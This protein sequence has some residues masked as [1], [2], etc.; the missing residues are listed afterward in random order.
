MWLMAKTL[1]PGGLDWLDVVMLL[2]FGLTLPWTVIG[3]WNATIGLLLMR[4]ADNSLARVFP[5][6]QGDGEG[7]VD[8]EGVATDQKVAI[9]SC[10]RNEDAA[11]V[12]RNLEQIVA[13]LSRR[14]VAQ[15]FA[16]HVLS[17][18]TWSECISAEERLMGAFQ[19]R[20]G[21]FLP[22]SYRRRQDNPG[23]KAG[24]IAEFM[25]RCAV[26]FDFALVLDADSVMDPDTVLRMLRIMQANPRLGILQSLVVG[27][28]SGSAFARI[29]QFGMRFGMRSFTLGSAWWQGDCGPY[30]GH[31]ALLRVRPFV[32]HCRLAP[33]SGRGPL[34]GWVLSHDQ[35]EAVLMRRAGYQVRVLPEESGSYEENP[36]SLLEYIRR[37][38]RWCQG[39]LQYF[40]LLGTGGLHVLGRVQLLLAILMFIGSP[41]WVLLMVMAASRAFFDTTAP[42]FDPG[43]G[44]ALLLI[45]LTM[46]FA[47]KL[48]S[49]IDL[50]ANSRRRNA[51]GGA[52]RV[53]AGALGEALFSTLLAPVLAIAHSVFIGGLLVG[54]KLVWEPQ[55]RLTHR[56]PVALAWWR[57]WPQTLIG[58]AATFALATHGSVTVALLSPFFIGALVAVPLAVWSASPQLGRWVT[59][60]RLWAIPEEFS[61]SPFLVSLDL[62]A[63]S[64]ANPPTDDAP[65]VDA[66]QDC[67][68]PVEQGTVATALP[69]DGPSG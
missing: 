28:P 67:D 53:L 49:L 56:V 54:R 25:D 21:Q 16:V 41:F 39:N 6:D 52:T 64:L 31:N 12:F 14:G 50:L 11:T 15:S 24:N 38:L 35:L 69:A 40:R 42:L 44:V 9:L 8:G 66:K 61:P 47:P 7:E 29:F 34:S 5:L 37:D 17:D 55:R 30:W 36:T 58:L 1:S 68:L 27:L 65:G 48:A 26:H 13:G 4:F 60:R 43:Y 46:V 2:C 51:Y 23:F 62:D 20:W 45:I 3:F 32:E 33:I 22:V 10:I 19:S 18:S 63:I 57:L 59:R